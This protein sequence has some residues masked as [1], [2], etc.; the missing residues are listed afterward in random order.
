MAK[1]VKGGFVD[2]DPAVAAYIQ[3][4]ERRQATRAMTKAQR[5][6]ASRNKMT[7][8]LPKALDD[9]LHVMAADLSVPVSQ[10]VQYLVERGLE[11]VTI[12]ELIEA[13]RPTRSMRYEFVLFSNDASPKGQL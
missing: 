5:R 4:G 2:I 9:R 8:D 6:Q 3:D 12:D 13:R 10:L 11:L 7:V 1:P